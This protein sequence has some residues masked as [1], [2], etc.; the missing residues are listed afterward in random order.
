MMMVSAKALKELENKRVVL[1]RSLLSNSDISDFEYESRL[2]IF[3]N[4]SFVIYILPL[5]GY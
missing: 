3:Y 1:N 2:K 4:I 5:L